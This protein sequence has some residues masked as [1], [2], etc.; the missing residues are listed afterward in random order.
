[1]QK[2]KSFCEHSLHIGLQYFVVSFDFSSEVELVDALSS[3]EL[4]NENLVA[5][6]FNFAEFVMLISM[7]IMNGRIKIR[8]FA[9]LFIY[10]N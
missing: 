8:N 1:M 3:K 7:N 6:K 4:P 10:F 5:D 9:L 2:F